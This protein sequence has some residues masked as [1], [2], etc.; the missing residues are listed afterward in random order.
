M[1]RPKRILIVE[2][3]R[4]LRRACEAGL[5]KRGFEVT[6][7]EHGAIG[8]QLALAGSFDLVLLDMLMPVM[9]G[10]EMLRALRS[11]EQGPPVPVVVLSNSSTLGAR[12]ETDRLG[13]SGYLVKASLSLEGLAQMVASLTKQEA[14]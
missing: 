7:A 8:L 14:A 5:R 1:S 13:V 12:N 2:D 9:N 6:T 3:D 10:I 11:Q 4:V